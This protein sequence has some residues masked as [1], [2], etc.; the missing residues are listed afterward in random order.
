M[1]AAVA[2]RSGTAAGAVRR[3]TVEAGGVEGS[4][5]VSA[6][7]GASGRTGGRG[8]G[9]A[10]GVTG[11]APPSCRGTTDPLPAALCAVPSTALVRS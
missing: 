11:F 6:R 5:E 2:R 4:S 8:D 7:A 1:S 9:G 10:V 3:C